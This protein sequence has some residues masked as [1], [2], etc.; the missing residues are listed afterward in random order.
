[1]PVS[2]DPRKDP[3]RHSGQTVFGN[4]ESLAARLDPIA[5]RSAGRQQIVERAVDSL[6]LLAGC[7]LGPGVEAA[8]GFVDVI[9]F[10]GGK[11]SSERFKRPQLSIEPQPPLRVWGSGPPVP[12]PPRTPPT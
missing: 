7:S 1:M 9:D 3:L 2:S 12:Q 5:Q 4:R 11:P 10:L 6:V 8:L